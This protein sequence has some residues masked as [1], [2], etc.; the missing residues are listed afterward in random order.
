METAWRYMTVGMMLILMVAGVSRA[1]VITE[2]DFEAG[3]DLTVVH[4]G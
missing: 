2:V 1:G 3:A 4:N